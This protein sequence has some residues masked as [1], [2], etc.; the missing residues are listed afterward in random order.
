MFGAMRARALVLALLPTITGC[1]CD[2]P[3]K[4]KAAAGSGSARAGAP[5][6]SAGSAAPTAAGSAGSAGSAA[7]AAG[8][9]CTPE[10][11]IRVSRVLTDP[12]HPCR[13]RI[14]AAYGRIVRVG[15]SASGT[16]V[17]TA[18][19]RGAGLLVTCR[20]CAG[21]AGDG[22]ADPERAPPPGFRIGAPARLEG[23]AVP[24]GGPHL[25]AYLLFGDGEVALAAIGGE[26]LAPGAAIP[27]AVSNRD[28]ALDDPRKL[29]AAPAPFLDVG[30]GTAVLV[31]GFE[32]GAG[33]E[34][35]ASVGPVLADEEARRRGV[36]PR[37]ELA[38]AAHAAPGLAGGGVF[39]ERG[40]FVGVVV[41][42]GAPPDGGEP[43]V[44][45]VRATAIAA[46]LSAALRTAPVP[47]RAKVLPFLP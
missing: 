6:E 33:G 30:A 43:I 31:L 19:A 42:A 37:S 24:A 11:A 18:S 32:G 22:L 8:S 34:L 29:A 23:D 28:V 45:A 47:L 27:A 14:L 3:S 39:D 35:V 7:A 46:R 1:T 17:S 2:A 9:T 10:T 16:I 44:R 41:P 38:I 21:I 25:A 15:E 12:A 40:R 13:A 36:D 4:P 26:P 20:A 5:S